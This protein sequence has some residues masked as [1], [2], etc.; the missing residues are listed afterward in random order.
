MG[1]ITPVAGVSLN[2]SATTI[3]TGNTETLI[4]SIAP[5]TATNKAVTWSSSN[6]AVASVDAAGTVTAHATGTAT[7]TAT[8]VDGS[9][10]EPR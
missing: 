5:A 6:A 4:A 2:K 8:T 7:I 1:K 3:Y 10:P 9:H